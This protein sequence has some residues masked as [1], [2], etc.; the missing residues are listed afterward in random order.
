MPRATDVRPRDDGAQAPPGGIALALGGG[1]ARAAYQVGVLRSLARRRPHLSVPVLTGVSAGAINA[2]QL[3]GFRGTFADAVEELRTLWLSI[4]TARV[5]RT[6]PA[7]LAGNSLRWAG[8]LLTGRSRAAPEARGLVDTAPL[9]RFLTEALRTRDG[10][11]PGIAQNIADGSLRAVA[12]TTTQYDTGRSITWVQGR[13]VEPWLRPQRESVLG[14]VRL[15]HILASAAI[16]LVFPAVRLNH[17]WHGDGGIGQVAP[18]SPALH[19]GGTRILT[20]STRRR[21]AAGD[22]VAEASGDYPPPAQIL[23]VL[24]DA[25]FLDMLDFDVLNM[26]R[27]TA[28]AEALPE[29]GRQGMRTARTFVLRPSRDLGAMAAEHQPRLPPLLRFLL[30]GIGADRQRSVDFLSMILFEPAFIR[31]LLDLGEADA[32]ARAT[33]LE[34]FVDG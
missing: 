6:D 29:S 20:V 19:L 23:S 33:E 1:G 26:N 32:D 27:I 31:R 4:E 34:A 18:L 10:E 25:V 14:T 15:E 12:I 5:F 30:G 22:P 2:V 24:L 11:L 16:P 17:R 28:L 7:S 13:A 3:A 8:S 9:R 21:S